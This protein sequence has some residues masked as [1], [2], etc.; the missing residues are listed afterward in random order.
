MQWIVR[1]AVHLCVCNAITLFVTCQAANHTK[2]TSWNRFNF[3]YLTVKLGQ[4]D[5][6]QKS[7]KA[8]S[9]KILLTLG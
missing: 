7:S 4:L 8:Q 5:R 1:V 6:I 9:S 2:I 3:T